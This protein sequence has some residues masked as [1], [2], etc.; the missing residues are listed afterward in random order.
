[1]TAWVSRSRYR[2]VLEQN[3]Q[4]VEAVVRASEQALQVAAAARAAAAQ[5]EETLIALRNQQRREH[6]REAVRRE[7]RE[8][9]ELGLRR[10]QSVRRAAEQGAEYEGGSAE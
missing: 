7:Q 10:W 5:E 2:T 8:L 6:Q 1:M 3:L 4:A 9:D